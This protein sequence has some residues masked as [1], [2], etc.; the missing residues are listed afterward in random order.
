MTGKTR[1]GWPL[2]D[3]TPKLDADVREDIEAAARDYLL[4]NGADITPALLESLYGFGPGRVAEFGEAAIAEA[5]RRRN[6]QGQN[7]D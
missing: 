7:D 6:A 5:R 4:R 2:E 1:G 3:A